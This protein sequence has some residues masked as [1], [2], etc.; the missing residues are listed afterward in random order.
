MC[1]TQVPKNTGKLVAGV[2]A[3]H[4]RL[5]SVVKPLLE[6]MNAI[7]QRAV[8]VLEAAESAEDAAEELGELVRINMAL[9]N[10][11]GVGH[12]ALDNVA[13]EAAARGLSAKLTGAGELRVVLVVLAL[14]TLPS[15][16]VL[17]GGGGCAMVLLSTP[18]DA[19]EADHEGLEAALTAAGYDCFRSSI[20]GQGVLWHARGAA[21]AAFFEP[22]GVGP[23]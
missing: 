8:A 13:R 18:R 20:G 2:K 12:P 23:R 7:A 3:L 22:A 17:T 11:I 1:F 4:D 19:P 5:P 6:S 15:C 16:R 10:A 9:L 21:D 14:L